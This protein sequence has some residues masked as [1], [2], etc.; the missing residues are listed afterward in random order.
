MDPM[1]IDTSSSS[2]SAVDLPQDQHVVH[3]GW[4]GRADDAIATATCP[5][6][7]ENNEKFEWIFRKAS[8]VGS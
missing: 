2:S 5:E 8:L 4:S 6:G 3:S 7:G 1:G